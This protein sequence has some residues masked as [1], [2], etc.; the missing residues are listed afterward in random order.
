VK[1]DIGYSDSGSQ[2]HA[3]GLDCPVQVHVKNG[4]LIVPD[5][6]R[7]V[8]YVVTNEESSIVTGIGIGRSHGRACS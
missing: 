8:G 7:R 4:V 1:V 2:W 5:P 3:K 6:F